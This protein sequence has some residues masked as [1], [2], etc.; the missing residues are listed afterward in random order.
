MNA[1]KRRPRE[2]NMIAVASEMATT[3][4]LMP[5]DA[6]LF[7]DWEKRGLMHR[8]EDGS[9]RITPSGESVF[10]ALHESG[11]RERE[12]DMVLTENISLVLGDYIGEGS[13]AAVA[14]RWNPLV[15]VYGLI[16]TELDVYHLLLRWKVNPCSWFDENICGLLAQVSVEH[17][18]A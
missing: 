13:V 18:G 8:I 10:W 1:T 7:A 14:A 12:I 6:L 15:A 2:R 16:L 17:P 11:D 5:E 3:D 9:W 4:D